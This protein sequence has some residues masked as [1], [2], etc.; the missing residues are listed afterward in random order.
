MLYIYSVISYHLPIALI[1]ELQHKHYYI[2]I[3]ESE[4]QL[5]N[6]YKN[7][8]MSFGT[9]IRKTAIFEYLLHKIL[10]TAFN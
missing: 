7:S 10:Y 9:T 2:E 6:I 8:N 1:S 4:S 5:H 3:L